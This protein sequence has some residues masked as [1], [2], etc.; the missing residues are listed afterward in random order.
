MAKL[1]RIKT[2]PTDIVLRTAAN[3]TE[4]VLGISR[5]DV[6][7]ALLGQQGKRMTVHCR[8]LVN[9]HKTTEVMLRQE[10][11]RVAGCDICLFDDYLFFRQ[12]VAIGS[13]HM[14]VIPLMKGDTALCAAGCTILLAH[15]ATM[16]SSNMGLDVQSTV[17]SF[18][19]QAIDAAAYAAR[20][21]LEPEVDDF[22]DEGDAV[23]AS[24]PLSA[25][26]ATVADFMDVST[27][28]EVALPQYIL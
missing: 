15:S 19:E 18:T 11:I 1:C 21:V 9:R 24:P 26:A 5:G 25:K 2:I 7:I 13:Y 27:L 23:P 12:Y 10:V 17:K 14:A 3:T 6:T 4:T 20:H 8:V 16:V 22:T 28:A